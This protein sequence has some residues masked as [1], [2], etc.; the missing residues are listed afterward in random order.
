MGPTTR[1]NAIWHNGVNVLVDMPQTPSLD[2]TDAASA[3]VQKTLNRA[4]LAKIK[5]KVEHIDYIHPE[6]HP[7][8]TLCLVT[9]INGFVLVGK[10]AP[11]DPANYNEELGFRFSFEDALRQAWPLEAYLI[12][13]RL[14]QEAEGE[15]T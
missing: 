13:E 10:S 7:H 12:R 8:M 2:E 4:E 1:Y 6:R 14:T 15:V 11:A 9:M 3:V 5:D